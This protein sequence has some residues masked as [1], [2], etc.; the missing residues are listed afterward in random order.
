[1]A[2]MEVTVNWIMQYGAVTGLVLNVIGAVTIATAQSRLFLVINGWLSAL[3][4][5]V[6]TYLAKQ[7][8]IVVRFTG[9]DKQMERAVP[10][11]RKL[12]ALGWTLIIIGV[13]LQIP[14]ALP[15]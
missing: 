2:Y 15:K 14:A 11:T 7:S 6:E 8:P 13:A 12:S 3:D 9:W 4:L 5:F 10:V 1:M